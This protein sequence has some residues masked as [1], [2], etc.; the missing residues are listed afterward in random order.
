MRNIWIWIVVAVVVVGGFVWWWQSTQMPLPPVDTG[1]S[2]VVPGADTTGTTP[3][4]VTVNYDG[5]KFTPSEVTIKKGDSVTWISSVDTMEV[6]S[7]M[8]PN[9]EA[10]DGTARAE[11]CAAG[12]AG[13]K[14]FDQCVEGTSYAFV[15]EKTGTFPYH[16]HENAK[17]FGRVIVTE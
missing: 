10:F 14:P 16:D 4:A 3:A 11:H 7:A 13:P 2:S 6:A 1:A 17:A 12:Y 5:T 8:H 9:H 15:F